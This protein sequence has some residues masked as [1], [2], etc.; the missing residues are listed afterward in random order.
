MDNT[1]CSELKKKGL[2]QAKKFSWKKMAGSFNNIID[3]FFI[4]N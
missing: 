2:D 1:L 4:N 3:N